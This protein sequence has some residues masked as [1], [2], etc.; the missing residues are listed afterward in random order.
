MSDSSR[1]NAKASDDIKAAVTAVIDMYLNGSRQADAAML[2]AALYSSCD[3]HSI[4]E[5][6]KLEIVARDRFIDFAGAGKLPTH[7]SK[8]LQL[9]IVNNMASAKVV[10]EF[11]GHYFVDFLTLLCIQER[12]RIVNKT[13][14][15]I[16]K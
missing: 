13:Y 3:L 9:D 10:F 16:F 14:T 4:T 7:K 5:A 2:E 11:E 12:W 1:I 6:G 8:L 15:K